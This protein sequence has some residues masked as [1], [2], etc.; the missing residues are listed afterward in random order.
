MPHKLHLAQANIAHMRMPLDDPSMGDFVARIDA[1]NALADAAPGFVWRLEA[2]EDEISPVALFSGE[3]VLFNL[4]VWESIE[5]L[6]SYVYKSDHVQAVQKR[7]EWFERPK[8]TPLVLW[9]VDAGHMPTEEEAAQRFELLWEKGPTAD[10]FT[11]RTRFEP[12]S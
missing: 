8:K 5:S 6:E 9:W 2:E 10:A 1:L 7:A 4:T 11:F 3:R 12:E